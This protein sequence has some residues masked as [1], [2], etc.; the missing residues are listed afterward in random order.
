MLNNHIKIHRAYTLLICVLDLLSSQCKSSHKT[1]YVLLSAT[2]MF[3]LNI[4]MIAHA[5]DQ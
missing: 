2:L 5:K 4:I 1:T 3:I